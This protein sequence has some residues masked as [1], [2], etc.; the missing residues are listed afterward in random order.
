M[1]YVEFTEAYKKLVQDNEKSFPV[2]GD[3]LSWSAWHLLSTEKDKYE[4]KKCSIQKLVGW[5]LEPKYRARDDKSLTRSKW[6]DCCVKTFP[7][8]ASFYLLEQIMKRETPVTCWKK[9][10]MLTVVKEL[11]PFA[12]DCTKVTTVSQYVSNFKNNKYAEEEYSDFTNA[13]SLALVN[14]ED[15]DIDEDNDTGS[16]HP[17]SRA[18]RSLFEIGPST[19]QLHK[20]PYQIQ[21]KNNKATL[22]FEEEVRNKIKKLEGIL[23][24]FEKLCQENSALKERVDASEEKLKDTTAM[25]LKLVALQKEFSNLDANT[26]E[27]LEH[28]VSKTDERLATVEKCLN[29]IFNNQDTNN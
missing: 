20:R 15:N 24:A 25:A 11:L 2:P 13:S 12:P 8:G 7:G 18:K 16:Y 28:I 14:D 5:V 17:K 26:N 29:D 23:P 19:L 10:Y 22:Q 3:T 6:F 4:G 9:P 27:T 1:D 21:K